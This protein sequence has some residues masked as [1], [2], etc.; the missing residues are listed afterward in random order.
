MKKVNKLLAA[1]AVLAFAVMGS[2]F[3]EG[4]FTFENKISTD[5]VKLGDASDDNHRFPGLREQMKVEYLGEKV[6]AKG[7]ISVTVTGENQGVDPNKETIIQLQGL[8][9]GFDGGYYIKFRPI[10]MLQFALASG[11]EREFASGAYLP[12]LDDKIWRGL[13][14]GNVGLLVKP[15]D[16]LS[17]GAGIDTTTNLINTIDGTDKVRLN[18]GAEYEVENIGS[19]ALAFNNVFNRF[20][21]G[22]FAKITAISDMDIYT[23]FSYSSDVDWSYVGYSSIERLDNYYEVA[24]KLLLNA[25]FE[26]TGVDKLTLAADFVTNLFVETS[27]QDYDLYL[28]FKAAYDVNEKL[29]VSGTGKLFFDFVDDDNNEYR[30][31]CRSPLISIS[32]EV[33]YKTGNH[34]FTAGLKMEFWHTY[35]TWKD[36]ERE[37]QFGM[38]FPVSW[39]YSF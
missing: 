31:Y 23:G 28:G 38:C 3:A 13:Y 15:I 27:H 19:F 30:N 17:I 2:V 20:G 7:D 37:S 32:P 35:S 10:E 39:S 25:G 6:D 1:G 8:N 9:L 5:T 24:G 22:A 14:T 29:S 26:F 21:F 34:K 4:D 36:V 18:F 33:S 12:V 11:D 16:G